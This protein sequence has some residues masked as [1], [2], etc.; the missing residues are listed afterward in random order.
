MS[1]QNRY[2]IG[3]CSHV[4]IPSDLREGDDPL[5]ASSLLDLGV[6]TWVSM[7]WRYLGEIANTS[8]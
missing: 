7:C 2:V 6:V 5:R 8:K 1:V 4:A 3:T